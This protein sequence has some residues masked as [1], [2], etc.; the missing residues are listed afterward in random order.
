MRFHSREVPRGVRVTETASEWWEPGAGEGE[1]LV[2]H[3]DRAPVW[4]GE[5]KFWRR[6]VGTVA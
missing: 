3:G 4:I 2:L 6:M 1:E 5:R